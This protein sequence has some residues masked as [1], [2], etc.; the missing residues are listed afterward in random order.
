MPLLAFAS[1]PVERGASVRREAIEQSIAAG[2]AQRRLG[3]ALTGGQA[4]ARLAR[5]MRRVP[6]LRRRVVFQAH[7]VVVPRD[8]LCRTVA[9]CLLLLDIFGRTMRRGVGQYRAVPRGSFAIP[10]ENLEPC[11]RLQR[12]YCSKPKNV[13]TLLDFRFYDTWRSV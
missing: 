6:R 8:G 10:F 4:I 1:L 12:L 5:G 13:S 7:A 11:E 2:A 3:A 9:N